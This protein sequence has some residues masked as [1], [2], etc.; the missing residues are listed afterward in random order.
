MINL[1]YLSGNTTGGW[2]TYTAHLA[3]G[4]SMLADEEYRKGDRLY[5]N[6]G[7]RLF[8]VGNNTETKDRPF[9]YDVTYRNLHLEQA[10]A[11]VREGPGASLI[12]ALQKNY[13]DQATE[14]L[15]AGAW[16]VV[17]D[18]AEFKNLTLPSCARYITIR[19]AVQAQMPGSHFL[20]HPYR[21]HF[22]QGTRP[23]REWNA[24]SIARIDFDKHTTIL[25]DA[26]RLLPESQRIHIH[27]FEN[28]LYT[29][30]KVCPQYPEW[31]QSV[32]HYPRERTAATEI[33][34]KATYSCDMSVIKGDG[35]GTQYTF[36]E[37]MDAGSVN[38]INKKWVLPDDEMVPF[39]HPDANCFAVHDGAGLADVLRSPG[40]KDQINRMA[41]RGEG[42]LTRH[43][44]RRVA[45]QL[46]KILED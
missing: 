46:L 9:G 18:P 31:V 19:R 29:K 38:V 4:L 16:M 44:P 1:F 30:F 8:K 3:Y 6:D 34:H 10:V 28:R 40:A 41:M 42:L 2:V 32:S 22:P 21:R 7:Y 17:H 23:T 25:L 33:C 20:P 39:P 43:H 24:C 37:A 27:G 13:K 5:E 26:N 15:K 12:V 36:M 35:G 11:K 14:L 45:K